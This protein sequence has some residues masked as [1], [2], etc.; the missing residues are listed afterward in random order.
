M[1][2][3]IQRY[4]IIECNPIIELRLTVTRCTGSVFYSLVRV[5]SLAVGSL[6][7]SLLKMTPRKAGLSS[8]L[9]VRLISELYTR[10]EGQGDVEQK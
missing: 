3:T 9:Q 8:K 4:A 7:H 6:H 10:I 5:V 2:A 1:W